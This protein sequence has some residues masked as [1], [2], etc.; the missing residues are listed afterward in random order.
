MYGKVKCET[1]MMNSCKTSQADRKQG[2]E[3]AEK[4]WL[5]LNHLIRSIQNEKKKESEKDRQ[6]TKEEFESTVRMNF[7]SQSF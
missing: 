3:A 7:Q 2:S 4:P 5:L 6:T 1:K